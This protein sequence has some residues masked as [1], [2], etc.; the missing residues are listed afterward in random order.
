MSNL[1]KNISNASST[2]ITAF[3]RDFF[4]DSIYTQPEIKLLV[5]DK[6]RFQVLRHTSVLS[7]KFTF[8]S[9]YI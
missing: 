8:K 7:L 2:V 3:V 4:L 9:C 5:L 1:N 6:E